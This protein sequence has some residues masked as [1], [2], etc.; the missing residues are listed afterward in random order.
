MKMK[1]RSMKKKSAAGLATLSVFALGMSTFVTGCVSSGDSDANSSAEKTDKE[2]LTDVSED[3]LFGDLESGLDAP[4]WTEEERDS[5]NVIDKAL[6]QSP[7]KDFEEAVPS[8][9]E[10]DSTVKSETAGKS[11][12]KSKKNSSKKGSRALKAASKKEK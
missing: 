7:Y 8:S 2:E 12:Q 1:L 6:S 10:S 4:L 5:K 11:S 9:T 3:E